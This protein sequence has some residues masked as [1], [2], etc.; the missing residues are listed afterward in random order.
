MK[1]NMWV[2]IFAGLALIGIILSIIWTGILFLFESNT[3]YPQEIQL[4]E[5]EIQELIQAQ[6]LN[7]SW[8][9]DESGLLDVLEGTEAS[10]VIE[11]EGTEDVSV[12]A[13]TVEEV[14]IIEGE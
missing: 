12:E 7:A 2:K 8:S 14:E 4:T 13:V 10:E 1:K 3:S 5:A 9:I 6:Q 11:V